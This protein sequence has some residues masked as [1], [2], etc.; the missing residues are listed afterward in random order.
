MRTI[1]EIYESLA[2]GFAQAAG[3]ALCEGGDMSLRLWAV[4]AEL[5]SLEAQAE[6]VERQCFPQTAVGA[7]LD[8]HA[9]MRG[10]KRGEATKAVGSLRFYTAAA[11]AADIIVPA[12]TECMNAAGTAFITLEEGCVAAGSSWCQVA[13]EAL[14]PGA[15][16]NVPAESIVYI[17]LAPAGVAGVTNTAA[18]SGGAGDESDEELR[19]RVVASYRRLSNGANEAWY[20]DRVLDMPGVAAVTVLPRNRGIGTVDIVFSAD[21]GVP[22]AE[23]IGQVKAALDSEREICVD[24]GVSAPEAVSVDVTAAVSVSPGYA[25]ESVK[26]AA[27]EALRACFGGKNLGRSVYRAKLG[28]ALMAVEGLE[29][30]SLSAPAADVSISSVQLPVL[31]T[32]TVSEAV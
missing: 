9:E 25:F 28:A 8:H 24:I 5:F 3:T 1:E 14:E 22:S 15:G 23:Q 30:Y 29:N 27:E 20:Q 31:G 19:E 7:Y 4:A 2:A 13:A 21:G 11:A 17:K 16:G 26:A 6:F 18:F 32:L 12:G 10:L